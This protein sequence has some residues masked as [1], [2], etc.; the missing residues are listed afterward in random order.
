MTDATDTEPDVA[1]AELSQNLPPTEPVRVPQYRR[2]FSPKNIVLSANDL[3]EFCELLTEANERARAIEYNNLNLEQ[4]DGPEPAR[5]RVNELMPLEYSYKASSGDSVTGLGIPKTDEH[6]FPDDLS[7]FFV[8]NAAY[9]SRAVNLR[10]LNTVEVFLGFEKPS[11]KIDLVTL[12]SNPTENRS[13]IEVSGRDEDW[14]ISTTDR[15][16]SFLNKRSAFRPIIHGSGTYDYFVYLGFLPALLW[17]FYKKGSPASA[18]LESQSVFLNVLIGIYVLL[19]SLLFA[20]FVFQYFRW[21]FPPMEYYKRSRI[22]AYVHRGV[23]GLIFSSVLVSAG[24]D[25]L[26]ATFLSL[27]GG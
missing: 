17:L 23:A 3:R 18:W 25:L 24:Y 12:P 14:V 9:A 2:D 1:E 27:V 10:P 8:S 20:R 5:D 22:G 16:Q 15:I 26:K 6:N 19:L 11:L 7:S 4:Y 13:V 21:L